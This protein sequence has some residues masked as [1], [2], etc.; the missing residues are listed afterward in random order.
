MLNQ[1]KTFETIILNLKY[2]YNHIYFNLKTYT[3]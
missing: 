2:I 1:M 3:R